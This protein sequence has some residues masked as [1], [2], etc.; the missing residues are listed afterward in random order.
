GWSSY[1]LVAL[2]RSSFLAAALNRASSRSTSCCSR[3]RSCAS[4]SARITRSLSFCSSIS[5]A[6]RAILASTSCS[7]ASWASRSMLCCSVLLRSCFSRFFTSLANAA[8]SCLSRAWRF[9]NVLD[10]CS[11]CS[12]L[13]S[14]AFLS[15]A[16]LARSS[17]SLCFLASSAF[18]ASSTARTAAVSSVCCSNSSRSI[19]KIGLLEGLK[20]TLVES[21][22]ASCSE[23]SPPSQLWH[24]GYVRESMEGLGLGQRLIR[25]HHQ[26]LISSR[27]CT[28][29]IPPGSALRPPWQPVLPMQPA[30]AK[31]LE[32]AGTKRTRSR[33][34]PALHLDCQH[35]DRR[36]I[37]RL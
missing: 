16:S 26:V 14:S 25:S 27:P 36:R 15:L 35:C 4:L 29:C 2:M 32:V 34:R 28:R 30:A 6:R 18:F 3:S 19:C 10:S 21:R 7:C 12:F 17:R 8:S 1:S 9:S 23:S 24:S 13:I 31:R 37:P 5:P 11:S 22:A 33:A 20:K